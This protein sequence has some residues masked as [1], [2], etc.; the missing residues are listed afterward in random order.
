M[1][2]TNVFGPS[3]TKSLTLPTNLLGPDLMPSTNV[4]GPFVTKSL[5]LHKK[6]GEQLTVLGGRRRG[7]SHGEADAAD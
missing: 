5:T 6:V 3:V 4:C 1:L 2:S 7:R